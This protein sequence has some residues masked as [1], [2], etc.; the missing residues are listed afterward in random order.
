MPTFPFRTIDLTHP[1]QP[2]MPSWPGDPQ[3]S[4]T[5]H[6]RHDTDQYAMNK[7][8]IGEHTG[9]HVGVAGHRIPGGQTMD[10][11]PADQLVLPL[12]VVEAS[13]LVAVLDLERYEAEH[14]RIES[15]SCVALSTGWAS[16]WPDQQLVF[17]RGINGDFLWPGFS[18][19]AVDWL[20]HE[21][22]V[23]ALATDA[24]DLGP[25]SDTEL[26]IGLRCAELGMLHVENLAKLDQM[27]AG[28]GFVIIGA[29]P[30]VGGTGS[31]ARVFGL[32][33]SQA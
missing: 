22:G 10:Q 23:S 30:L 5:I 24:P 20:K 12:C 25:G 14:G 18:V 33:S 28:G 21:R 13:E 4:R 15:G 3:T 32:V 31:P 2:D 19:E 6:A 7:W 8:S 1:I 17:G 27:P 26:A 16:R 29:L 11:L 9:T